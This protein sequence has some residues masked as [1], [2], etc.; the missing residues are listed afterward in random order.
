M[1][2]GDPDR[3][4]QYALVFARSAL[5]HCSVG[6]AQLHLRERAT[7][8]TGGDM[9]AARVEQLLDEVEPAGPT[10]WLRP[11]APASRWKPGPAGEPATVTRHHS[12]EGWR[13]ARSAGLG[14]SQW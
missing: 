5:E 2:I 12:D 14:G 8:L 11:P 3:D 7:N 9:L 10:P 13:P 6:P 4:R 1:V